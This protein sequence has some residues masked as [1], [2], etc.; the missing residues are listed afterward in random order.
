MKVQGFDKKRF[1]IALT[2]IKRL[3]RFLQDMLHFARPVTMRKAPNSL[4]DI[5]SECLDL[6]RDKAVSHSIR[7]HWTKPRQTRKVLV[8]FS[9]MEEVFLNIFLNSMDAMPDGGEIR[10][11][12]EEVS[13]ESGPMIEVEIRDT[14][15][16]IPA[17]LLPRIFEPFYST[18]TE[19]AGLGLSNVK[20]I[21]DAHNGIIELG[22]RTNVG[23]SFKIRIPAE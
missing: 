21:V 9:K 14:G 6:L 4:P 18:K 20:R 10:V 2:E 5:I 15:S 17:E 19:G 23:T 16:G 11:T 7:L 12:V 13:T 1:E 8:D 3:D 22:S